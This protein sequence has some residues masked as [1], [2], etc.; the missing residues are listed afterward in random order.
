MKLLK[1]LLSLIP[2]RLPVGMKEFDAWAQSIRDLVGPGF[3]QVPFDD[4]KFVLANTIMH[5]GP[6]R[7]RVAKNYFVQTL[8]K[9]G[10]NQVASQI[11]QDVKVRQA[12]AQEAAKVAQAKLAEATA[13]A[14]ASDEQKIQASN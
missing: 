4:F 7:S 13:P 11:F 6:Q 14:G 1:F 9:G 5:L 2:V 3:E 8:R 10:A 12:E